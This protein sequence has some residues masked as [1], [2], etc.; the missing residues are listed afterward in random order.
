MTGVE[1][2]TAAEL[3]ETL[4]ALTR[5][6]WLAHPVWASFSSETGIASELI[7]KWDQAE[8]DTTQTEKP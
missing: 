3:V 2:P 1:H 4:R 7:S 6:V 5:A 8:Q